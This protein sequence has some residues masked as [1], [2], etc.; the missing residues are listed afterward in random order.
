M[1]F[2][3]LVVGCGAS[4][5]LSALRLAQHGLQVGL[6]NKGE[7]AESS[8]YWAQGGIA[9]VADLEDTIADHVADTL[10][11]GA[12]LC[13]AEVVEQ[14]VEQ[15]GDII[16]Q[17]VALG[18]PFDRDSGMLHFARE[19]GHGRPRIVHVQDATGRA[20]SDVLR[21]HV[22]NHANITH[23]PH[24]TAVDMI[25]RPD[26][27][28]MRAVGIYLL[29]DNK[30]IAVAARHV[31]LATGGAGK[32]YMFTT[33]P[34]TATGDGIAIA[35]RAGCA[36]TNME[37]MQFHPTSLYHTE[38]PRL[39]LTEALRGEGALLV[40]GHGHRFMSDYDPERM[41]LAPRDIVARAI[42][43]EIKKQGVDCMFLDA[44]P[45]GSEKIHHHF[46]NIHQ[47]LQALGIDMA[48]EPIPIVP[49]AH[50]LC[51]GVQTDLT[52]AT[53]VKHLYT[54]GESAC[55]GVHG[56]NRLASNSLLECLVMAEL[57]TKAIIN[58]G[59]NDPILAVPKW[60]D[61][62]VEREAERVQIKQNWDEIRAV[63]SNYVGLVRSNERLRRARRRLRIVEEE[64]AH[65]YWRYPLSRD[66]IELRN[67][68]QVAT[69]TIRSA[70]KR[71]ESRGLHY[72]LDYPNTKQQAID[73]VL[74]PTEDG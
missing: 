21:Q 15:S 71:K 58:I 62:G 5:M 37:M 30:V 61:S 74:I 39:L 68:A 59:D 28:A 43:H 27:N 9:G 47:R 67:L 69:L 44:R 73:T 53:S 1:K 60:D 63:M 6:V 13:K 3:V 65:Y 52:G 42:D 57:S 14:M 2:D 26:G 8:T 64:I 45:L 46:P 40:D 12:G 41:E 7:F 19:G 32:A 29:H 20:V 36:V 23:L 72:S 33:N 34:D 48:S 17:L 35:W 16:T 25:L 51:G 31:V 54:I 70:L 11:A 50:Y 24:H 18:I 56:A 22:L 38:A 66:L 4:G 10:R 55:T 49:S